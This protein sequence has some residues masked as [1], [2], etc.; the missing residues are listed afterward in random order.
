MREMLNPTAAIMGRGLDKVALITDGRF[1]GGSR[2]P[3]IGHISPEAAAGGPIGAIENGD[4]VS[5]NVKERSIKLEL[6]D[7]EIEEKRCF[8]AAQ[9]CF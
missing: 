6:S 3:C 1:S 7:E 2:G 8:G 9:N 4:I 5:I